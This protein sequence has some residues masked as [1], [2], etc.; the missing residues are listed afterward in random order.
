MK[1]RWNPG[2]I[3]W[4]CESQSLIGTKI[5]CVFTLRNQFELACGGF[6]R[7]EKRPPETYPQLSWW[8]QNML[9]VLNMFSLQPI[10]IGETAK[11]GISHCRGLPVSGTSQMGLG[12]N[13]AH[14]RYSLL[15]IGTD[16]DS[17]AI[18]F[19]VP[20]LCRRCITINFS[21]WNYQ[22]FALTQCRTKPLVSLKQW[23]ILVKPHALGLPKH[24]MDPVVDFSVARLTS[25]GPPMDRRRLR[26]GDFFDL[27]ISC[28]MPKKIAQK[29]ERLAN[30]ICGS[31]SKP[32][33]SISCHI[34]SYF[35]YT[36]CI[37]IYGNIRLHFRR[38][39]ESRQVLCQGKL[40][41]L[42]SGWIPLDG[43]D[44]C[45]PGE[46]WSKEL[47]CS[48]GT[49]WSH[50]KMRGKMGGKWWRLNFFEPESAVFLEAI[51]Y[52]SWAC[53]KVG[54]SPR[55]FPRSWIYEWSSDCEW[56]TYAFFVNR[57]FG[58]RTQFRSLGNRARCLQYS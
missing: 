5:G 53:L 51:W 24:P 19:L 4:R 41:Q 52:D 17:F 9:P 23:L 28:P 2:E 14:F 16:L 6:G 18:V 11:V 54:T 45:H 8:K 57:I 30:R 58:L 21:C 37:Y 10:L 7:G 15:K 40:C 20:T 34:I 38:T 48:P 25:Y 39:S 1:S 56:K 12:Q 26:S 42:Q 43:V 33:T 22:S 47:G 3:I 46:V 32:L 27:A 31:G 36:L 35:K 13:D 50:G 44:Q 49:Q 55:N 29:S